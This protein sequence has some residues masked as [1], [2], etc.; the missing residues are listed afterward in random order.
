MRHP[1]TS[2]D[3]RGGPYRCDLRFSPREGQARDPDSGGHGGQPT[4]FRAR[5]GTMTNVMPISGN[6]RQGRDDLRTTFRLDIPN[7]AHLLLS[8]GRPRPLFG[9]SGG[10]ELGSL[11]GGRTFIRRSDGTVQSGDVRCASWP[12]KRDRLPVDLGRGRRAAVT[13]PRWRSWRAIPLSATSRFHALLR[14]NHCDQQRP[15]L[16]RVPR[17]PVRTGAALG[18]GYAL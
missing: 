7:V 10:R 15:S 14:R 12:A 2:A 8:A 13:C 9:R 17:P 6:S 16:R 4:R 5:P 1:R 3:P 11:S 18:Y